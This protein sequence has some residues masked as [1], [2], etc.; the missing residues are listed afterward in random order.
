MVH[1]FWINFLDTPG[2]PDLL[3]LLLVGGVYLVIIARGL[4][5]PLDERLRAA[6]SALTVFTLGNFLLA[7]L[8]QMNIHFL[9]L[10]VPSPTKAYTA[11]EDLGK[12]SPGT[13]LARKTGGQE[14]EDQGGAKAASKKSEPRL[15]SGLWQVVRE[16]QGSDSRRTE[17]F[18]IPFREWAIDWV[19][20]PE[21]S[22]GAFIVKV[23]RG[24]GK[25]VATVASTSG[26]EKDFRMMSSP[27]KYYLTID[28]TQKYRIVV[29]AKKPRPA[30]PPADRD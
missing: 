23:H 2:V 10:Q 15:R 29:S 19:T 20:T 8:F 30:A 21:G 25:L 1:D 12:H 9:V 4:N 26:P 3:A 13:K 14:T 22:P 5:P 18:P 16:W 17:T 11:T 24:D 6:G 28:S 27:G 7:A